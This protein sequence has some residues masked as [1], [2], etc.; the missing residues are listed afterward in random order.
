[1]T[2][3]CVFLVRSHPREV[4][5]LAAWGHMCTP[6]HPIIGW[7]SLPPASFPGFVMPG[8]A[9]GR[10]Q[11]L[12]RGTAPESASGLPRFASCTNQSGEEAAVHREGQR[13]RRRAVKTHRPALR[14]IVALGPHG[15]ARPAR[16][17][18]RHIE[19]SGLLSLP[20]ISRGC[21]RVPLTVSSLDHV[22]ETPP[23]PATPPRFGNRWHHTR[24]DHLFSPL[25]LAVKLTTSCRNNARR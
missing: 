21:D 15:G 5:R 4:S 17:T 6:I 9:L 10:L 13:V 19:A 23:W 8:L 16:V 25:C 3:C 14:A 11:G 12:T 7:R 2:V 22:L 18:R 24:L 20:T 1:L